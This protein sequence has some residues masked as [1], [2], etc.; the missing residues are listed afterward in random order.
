MRKLPALILTCLL[1]VAATS[2]AQQKQLEPVALPPA[3]GRVIATAFSPDSRS[4]AL[5]RSVS[6]ESAEN[7]KSAP[8][9]HLTLQVMNLATAEETAKTSIPNRVERGE[10]FQRHFL[11]YS[12]DGKRLLY[13]TEGSDQ[14]TILDAETFLVVRQFSLKPGK[15][16]PAAEGF[17]GIAMIAPAAHANVF[18]ILRHDEGGED[19]VLI[20]SF[21]SGEILQSWPVG[22]VRVATPL[23]ETSLALSGD[24]KQVA[25][26]VL[27]DA[28]RLPK[29]FR[30]LR[31]YDAESG[32]LLK[33]IRSKGLVGPLVV[34]NKE[35]ILAAR[36][37]LPGFFSRSNCFERWDMNSGTLAGRYC[38]A[39]M[40]A[41]AVD[42]TTS[43]GRVAGYVGRWHKA[44]DGNYYIRHGR[45]DVWNMNSGAPVASLGPFR[46]RGLV[47]ISPDG[48]WILVEQIL[49]QVDEGPQVF[50]RSKH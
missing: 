5:V 4:V 20:G 40:N 24:G 44:S 14:I 8:P 32:N 36:I 41:I 2:L 17:H 47:K 46:G 28:N 15:A 21:D 29:T 6:E 49:I 22:R 7:A 19:E 31:L 1:L 35:H 16:K 11:Y 34:L 38:A 45:V 27:P 33:S 9:V 25:L 30:N 12:A 37:D 39:K 13:A 43:T 42:A 48:K 23:G 26:S 50:S 18:G 3:P 10:A